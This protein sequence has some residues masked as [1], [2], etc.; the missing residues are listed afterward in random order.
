MEAAIQLQ[1]AEASARVYRQFEKDRALAMTADVFLINYALRNG[2]AYN[3]WHKIVNTMLEK[4]PG[5]PK[6]HR[7]RVIHIYEAQCRWRSLGDY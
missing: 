7:L 2:I 6:S 5:N 3:Q 4:D 1:R